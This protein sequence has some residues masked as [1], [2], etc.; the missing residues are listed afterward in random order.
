MPLR[1]STWPADINPVSTCRVSTRCAPH[2]L[3][4]GAGGAVEDGG[5]RHRDAAALPGLDLRPPGRIHQKAAVGGDA[6]E[7]LAELAVG[8]D[9]GRQPPHPPVDLAGADHLDPRR[10][11]DREFGDVPRRHQADQVEFAARDDGEQRLALARGRRADRRGRSRDQPGHRRLH[12]HR[13]AFGQVQPRQR[14]PRGDGIAGIRQHF[15]DLQPHPLRPHL[16]LLARNDGAGYLDRI[17]ETGFRRLE[18]G[19]RRA[20]GG[21]LG[22]V[23]GDGRLGGEGEQAGHEQGGQFW[24]KVA[25][26][27]FA[28]RRFVP[29]FTV[30]D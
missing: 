23:G 25:R 29:G 2:H 22:I 7:H 17:A 24:R 20:L 27:E 28:H 3:N 12:R 26:S 4:H 14:L 10:L 9:G 8:L 18:H 15:R 11:V 21:G 16:R 6:D 13:A 5:E 1:I 19:D 30:L